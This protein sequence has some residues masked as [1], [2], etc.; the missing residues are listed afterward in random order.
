M[1]P[2]KHVLI[3]LFLLSFLS[4]VMT[5]IHLFLP[6]ADMTPD[7]T[8]ASIASIETTCTEWGNDTCGKL[9][10]TIG[11][12]GDE[13]Y[14]YKF[15]ERKLDMIKRIHLSLTTE[16]CEY[17]ISAD[18]KVHATFRKC[19][20]EPPLTSPLYSGTFFDSD[21]ARYDIDKKS[22][23]NNYY[24]VTRSIRGATDI[25]WQEKNYTGGDRSLTDTI[26]YD[27]AKQEKQVKK[28]T[29][30]PDLGEFKKP[31]IE[32]FIGIDR[33]LYDLFDKDKEQIIKYVCMT[34]TTA[35]SLYSQM[36]VKVKLVGIRF[37]HELGF[38]SSA[39]AEKNLL[40]YLFAINWLIYGSLK[41][42]KL[43]NYHA[44]FSGIM[45]YEAKPLPHKIPGTPDAIITM[46]H[47]DFKDGALGW[48]EQDRNDKL[49]SAGIIEAV[50]AT[51]ATMK[52]YGYQKLHFFP[53]GVTL[54]HEVGHILFLRHPEF[55]H[56]DCF[57][58]RG[59][60]IMADTQDWMIPLWLK[61]E[62]DL[63]TKGFGSTHKFLFHQNCLHSDVGTVHEYEESMS[64]KFRAFMYFMLLAI[65]AT[66]ALIVYFYAI[67]VTESRPRNEY[68]PFEG[69]K[70]E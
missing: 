52:K 46:M 1:S 29:W 18:P 38:K 67:D 13:F 45:S 70:V 7:D 37:W 27:I 40:Q 41:I 58:H 35:D 24:L 65:A 43:S 39:F 23:N 26:R 50:F 33:S 60:C 54:A 44:T 4:I 32:L 36:G 2:L 64:P 61:N 16:T 66:D 59:R 3:L 57:T 8:Q 48:A 28:D 63:I 55:D 9:T 68:Q 42:T 47:K 56:P 31:V 12:P 62:T 20:A 6:R 25:H 15:E 14:K 5:D 22:G 21:N 34:V 11:P 53:A 30:I 17:F 19:V 51:R 69:V 49:G 10:V